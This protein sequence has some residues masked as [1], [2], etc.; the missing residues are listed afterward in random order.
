MTLKIK[1]VTATKQTKPLTSEEK[2]AFRLESPVPR[3]SKHTAAIRIEWGIDWCMIRSKQV[4][5]RHRKQKTWRRQNKPKHSPQQ[6]KTPYDSSLHIFVDQIQLLQFTSDSASIGV[7]WRQK[8][9]WEDIERQQN[10]GNRRERTTYPSWKNR[11]TT[12]VSTSP[13]IKT[14]CRNSRQIPH[15]LMYDEVE[16]R[17]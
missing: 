13:Y 14:H 7:W 15:R 16:T 3:R 10:D 1:K 8:K 9:W 17:G 2:H 6:K 4:V 12:R 5:R 11:L